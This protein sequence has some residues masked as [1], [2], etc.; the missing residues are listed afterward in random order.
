[1]SIGIDDVKDFYTT[2]CDGSFETKNMKMN[3]GIK[4]KLGKK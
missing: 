1:M 4:Q 2:Q 3:I